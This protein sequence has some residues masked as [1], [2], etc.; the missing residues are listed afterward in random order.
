MKK[1]TE[2]GNNI[3]LVKSLRFCAFNC[4]NIS[5]FGRC[6]TLSSANKTSLSSFNYTLKS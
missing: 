3:R 4:R 2:A 1:I 5:H 6:A